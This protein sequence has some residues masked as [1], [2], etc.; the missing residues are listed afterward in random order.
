MSSGIS[1]YHRTT[2]MEVTETRRI[3]KKKTKKNLLN[4]QSISNHHT[5]AVE[6]SF[7]RSISITYIYRLY[8]LDPSMW[9]YSI[10]SITFRHCAL[11]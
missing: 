4:D 2:G 11:R 9:I 5:F 3:F 8:S 10:L 6:M 1:F 7:Y